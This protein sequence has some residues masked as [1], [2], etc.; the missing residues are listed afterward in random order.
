MWSKA[1]TKKGRK[2]KRANILKTAQTLWVF[3]GGFPV[4]YY[5]F[6]SAEHICPQNHTPLNGVLVEFVN[7]S[8]T[9]NFERHLFSFSAKNSNFYGYSIKSI[10]SDDFGDKMGLFEVYLSKELEDL[11]LAFPWMRKK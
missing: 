7:E 2:K 5:C 1:D 8:H 10:N 11:I 9:A 3:N 6:S 4:K